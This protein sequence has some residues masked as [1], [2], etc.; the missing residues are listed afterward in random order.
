MNLP[1]F[2]AG[3]VEKGAVHGCI[4]GCILGVKIGFL[5]TNWDCLDSL[6]IE[7]GAARANDLKDSMLKRIPKC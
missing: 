5:V 7:R 4:E 1:S 6:E 2:R 3:V